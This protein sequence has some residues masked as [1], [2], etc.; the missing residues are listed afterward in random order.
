M[1]LKIN[2]SWPKIFLQLPRLPLKPLGG[3][4][5]L[6]AG[7]LPGQMGPQA[8]VSFPASGWPA[9]AGRGFRPHTF[10]GKQG[11]TSPPWKVFS[12]LCLLFRDS[13]KLS[14]SAYVQILLCTL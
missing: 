9:L 7:W 10:L 11:R 12:I 13:F 3:T 8:L 14:E 6:R 5:L 1:V 4:L 2:V